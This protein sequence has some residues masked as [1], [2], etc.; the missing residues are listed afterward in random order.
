MVMDF[1]FEKQQNRLEII[2]NIKSNYSIGKPSISDFE[3][4][5]DIAYYI[6][7][8]L[9]TVLFYRQ[10]SSLIGTQSNF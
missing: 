1:I 7:C 4:S 6:F 3:I 5:T 8:I 10:Y 2:I 9:F